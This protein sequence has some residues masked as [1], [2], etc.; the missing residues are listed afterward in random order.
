MSKHPIEINKAY[1]ISRTEW[2]KARMSVA[3]DIGIQRMNVALF[4]AKCAEEGVKPTLA[5][6][7]RSLKKWDKD[8]VSSKYE[9]EV[10]E[11]VQLYE[12]ECVNKA[13][14]PT[15]TNEGDK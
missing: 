2:E 8:I 3:Q 14:K 1:I 9:N 15:T 13:L 12:K 5:R 7:K 10:L 11:L 6:Y 4:E